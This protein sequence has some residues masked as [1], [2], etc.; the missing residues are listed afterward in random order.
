MKKLSLSAKIAIV[1]GV[2]IVGSATLSGLGI[3]NL[4]EVN[5]ALN[6][7]SEERIPRLESAYIVQ[8][9][10]RRMSNLL[11]MMA[12]EET[13]AARLELRQSL[14]RADVKIRDAIKTGLARSSEARIPDWKSIQ[15]QYEQWWNEAARANEALEKNDSA[16][17]LAAIHRSRS[18]RQQAEVSIEGLLKANQDYIAA[19]AVRTDQVY[20]RARNLSVLLSVFIIMTASLIAFF[21]MRAT[22]RAIQSVIASLNEGSLQVTGAAQQI[23]SSSEEL[24]QSTTEQAASLE[25]T[26]ASIEEM[27]SMVGKNSENARSV[28][29][30]STVS[31]EKARHGQEVVERMIQSMDEINKSNESLNQIVKVIEEIG[32]KTRVINDIVFQ[33]KLLSFNA[34]VEAARAGEHGKGFAVVA[35]EVGNLAQMSGNAAKEIS[36]LLEQSSLQ[37]NEMVR[38]TK[39]SVEKGVEVARDCGQVLNEIVT[40]VSSVSNMAAEISEASLEQSRGVQ[41]ITKAVSQLD[42]MTQMNAAT[43]EECA[44]AAEELA[45]QAESL[46]ASVQQLMLTIN[47][48]DP[49]A[50]VP[51]RAPVTATSARTAAPAGKVI[52]M[53]APSTTPEQR[54]PVLRIASGEPDYDHK[55]FRDV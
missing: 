5:G 3:Y 47:G 34:S 19:E 32:N 24:S 50:E 31:Q 17:V 28:S 41:E 30:N 35:E 36:T 18:F 26:A 13:D 27:N 49:T 6:E 16:G 53:R 42:Q 11:S 39:V 23:A 33:T 8:S 25:E 1:V 38:E 46:K 51:A 15:A 2:F 45:A 9:D 14:D 20:A 37:V 29:E 55:G 22:S 52:A 12:V 10:F 21:V 43:S 7:I 54:E 40:N 4:R 48:G 44:S